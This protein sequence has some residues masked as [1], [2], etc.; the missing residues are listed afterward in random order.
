MIS[1]PDLV[2]LL[3]G[4]IV[5]MLAILRY[6]RVYSLN[7]LMMQSYQRWES[8][9]IDGAVQGYTKLWQWAEKLRDDQSRDAYEYASTQALGMLDRHFQRYAEAEPRLKRAVQLIDEGLV[10]PAESRFMTCI[11]LALCH[12]GLHQDAETAAMIERLNR[13]LDAMLPAEQMSVS[14]LAVPHLCGIAGLP[15]L[16]VPASRILQ[17]IADWSFRLSEC[18]EPNAPMR[19]KGSIMSSIAGTRGRRSSIRTRKRCPVRMA[20]S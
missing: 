13:E 14:H 4:A 12:A 7:A 15:E 8:G 17:L 3:L 11:E 1:A 9:N 5:I 16:I 18:Q 20:L 6:R 2:V 10:Q 19:R